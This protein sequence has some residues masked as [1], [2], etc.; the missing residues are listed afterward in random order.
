[1]KIRIVLFATTLLLPTASIAGST[2]DCPDFFQEL[3]EE[4]M[5]GENSRAVDFLT[6][7]D[8]H[9]A[10]ENLDKHGDMFADILIEN[11]IL[12]Y[13]RDSRSTYLSRAIGTYHAAGL[14]PLYLDHRIFQRVLDQVDQTFDEQSAEGQL[15]LQQ[16]VHFLGVGYDDTL[17]L[18]QSWQ[19][20]VPGLASRYQPIFGIADAAACDD[21]ECGAVPSTLCMPDEVQAAK[22]AFHTSPDK[23]EAWMKECRLGVGKPE[24]PAVLQTMRES[25]IL[26]ARCSETVQYN[27]IFSVGFAAAQNCDSLLAQL[28]GLSAVS[29]T[30]LVA[31]RRYGDRLVQLG[32]MSEGDYQRIL[33]D[34]GASQ[35]N[36]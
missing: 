20:Y 28:P 10:T 21:G 25:G 30:D 3:S 23:I 8:E 34:S 29:S 18:L 1:M 16:A 35:E 24:T 11:S 17:P 27:A 19:H 31:I 22:S 12:E 32:R 5:L 13:F 33:G 15:Q 2:E 7:L 6:T 4:A 9:C 14:R 36:E 26:D